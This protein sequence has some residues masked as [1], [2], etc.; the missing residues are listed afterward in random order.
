MKLYIWEGEGISTGYHDDGTLVVLADSVGEARDI[1]RAN[2][3]AWYA[4]KK[5][6]D[7]LDDFLGVPMSDVW[8]DG[9]AKDGIYG[10][11]EKGTPNPALDRAPDRIVEVDAPRVVVFNGGGYD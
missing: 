5:A 2:A 1:A 3:A 4:A 10:E 9:M 11:F 7:E 6:A 8:S